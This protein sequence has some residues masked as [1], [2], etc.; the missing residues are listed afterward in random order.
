MGMSVRK[1]KISESIHLLSDQRLWILTLGGSLLRRQRLGRK[2]EELVMEEGLSALIPEE[3]ARIGFREH[4]ALRLCGFMELHRRLC[5][6]SASLSA[7]NSPEE[8]YAL[9]APFL[10]LSEKEEFFLAVLD[11]HNRV[12]RVEP[13]A[14]GSESLCTVDVLHVLRCALRYQGRA[15]MLAHN[16]PSG[17]VN[18]SRFD[19]DVTHEIQ[20]LCLRMRITLLDHIIVGRQGVFPEYYSFAQEGLI[21]P[22]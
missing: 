6:H 3:L 16:H 4:E 10:D 12:R 1:W 14:I 8:A 22:G 21:V 17:E 9:F 11:N 18:P 7:V 20:T 2:L 5:R 13:L 15:I 19:I